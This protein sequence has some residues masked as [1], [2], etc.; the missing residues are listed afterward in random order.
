MENPKSSETPGVERARSVPS[1]TVVDVNPVPGSPRVAGRAS[2]RTLV[3]NF[4]FTKYAQTNVGEGLTQAVDYFSF[5]DSVTKISLLESPDLQIVAKD[6]GVI[7]VGGGGLFD[8]GWDALGLVAKTARKNVPVVVWG[9]GINDHGRYD[10]HYNAV[11][12]DLERRP[13]VLVGLRDAFYANCVPCPSCMRPEF[14]D[15]YE[16]KHEVVFYKHH[17]FP[18]V[19]L[20]YPTMLNLVERDR[21]DSFRRVIR[22]LASAEVV[23]TNTYHGAYWAT[24]A[25][26]KVIV[27]RPFSNKFF[28]FVH[29]PVIVAGTDDIPS[30]LK[31]TRRYPEALS[32]ARAANE[33]FYRKVQSFIED[34]SAR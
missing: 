4:C 31:E 34:V 22:F 9:P 28:G 17:L 14:D 27:V 5:G 13:N 30:A 12:R 20:P 33:A 19:T 26:K 25:H 23:V 11:L 24:L 3:V 21:L 1:S 8:A 29:E 16:L 7:I 15:K 32:Q 18:D 10:R 6:P 2:R